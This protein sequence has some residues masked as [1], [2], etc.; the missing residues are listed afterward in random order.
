MLSFFRSTAPEHV[1][2][3]LSS[4]AETLV[5]FRRAD[6]FMHHS[7]NLNMTHKPPTETERDCDYTKGVEEEM[8]TLE[9]LPQIALDFLIV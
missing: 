4:P 6:L 3:G 1:L 8:E 7:K 9:F 2:H 5:L